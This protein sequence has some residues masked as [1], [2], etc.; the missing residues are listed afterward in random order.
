MNL[1]QMTLETLKSLA[2]DQLVQLEQTQQNLR[3]IN[4]EIAKR[5]K[6]EREAK[7]IPEEALP[8]EE[9]KWK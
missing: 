2:Y 3:L 8:K 4:E 1:Q 6:E 9:K 7:L 5:V